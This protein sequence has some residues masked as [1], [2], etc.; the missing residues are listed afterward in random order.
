MCLCTYISY[1]HILHF[2]KSTQDTVDTLN[3]LL[4]QV[5]DIIF[6]ETLTQVHTQDV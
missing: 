5:N 4:D 2:H 6:Q 3:N 1:V